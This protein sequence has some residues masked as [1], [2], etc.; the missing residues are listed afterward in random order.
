MTFFLFHA[1]L[2][3]LSINPICYSFGVSKSLD[4]PG[5][6]SAG[7]M[8]E[9]ISSGLG[10]MAAGIKRG[11]STGVRETE[12]FAHSTKLKGEVSR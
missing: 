6:D 3:A 4:Y 9:Q 1:A 12:A 7:R 8:A 2:N 10:K 5:L 11:V